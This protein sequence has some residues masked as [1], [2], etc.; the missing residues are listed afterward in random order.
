MLPSRID[1]GRH[2][3]STGGHQARKEAYEQLVP[4]VLPF[5]GFFFD[6]LNSTDMKVPSFD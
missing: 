2:F 4:R 6:Q 1:V 3:L 5:I